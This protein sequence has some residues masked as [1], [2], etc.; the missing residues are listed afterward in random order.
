MRPDEKPNAAHGEAAVDAAAVDATADAA[1]G[2][3][4]RSGDDEPVDAASPH[5]RPERTQR[6]IG[7][8]GG[9]PYRPGG[10]SG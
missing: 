4:D 8:A 7:S 1:A 10:H 5:A 9:G 6:R 2:S 3:C